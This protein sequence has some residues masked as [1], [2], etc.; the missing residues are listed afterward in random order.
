MDYSSFIE[1]DTL[2][3]TMTSNGYKY[4]TY[5]LWLSLKKADVKQK[6]LILCVD[7]ESYTF[8]RSMNVPSLL[9]KPLKP[10]L[11]GT[12]PSQFGSDTFMSYN[13]MKLEICEHIR[14]NYLNAKYIIYM[15]GDIIVFHDFIEYI[16]EEFE[17]K[18]CSFLFQCDDLYDSPNRTQCCTGFFAYKQETIDRSP[19][20]INDLKLWKE[21]R[22]DQPWVNKHVR[23]YDI[24]FDFLER[25]LFPNGVYIKDERWKKD[26]PYLLH[27]NHLVGN[28]KIS[29]MKRLN[30]WYHSY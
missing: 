11:P 7:K 6:L 25:S 23:L 4:L 14:L 21:I 18:N 29:T 16:K 22:E 5:N 10:V 1:N 20:I 30:M 28:A 24:R 13:F 12:Q 19:F 15:D 2:L 26:T 9:Y 27:F 3:W 8:F 17:K